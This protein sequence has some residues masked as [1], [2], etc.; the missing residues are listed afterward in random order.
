MATTS[1]LAGRLDFIRS[2]ERLK[3]VLRSGHTSSGRPESTAEHTWRLC[4]IAMTLQ[5]LLQPLDFERVLK[6]CIVHDLGEAISGDIPATVQ[7]TTVNKSERERR[8]LLLLTE[9]LPRH[10]QA[11]FLEL[12]AEYEAGETSE[13][14]VVKA[15]DKIE[16]II[17]HNQGANPPDFDYE[18]NISYGSKYASVHPVIAAL[19]ALV[20]EETHQNAVKAN[21]QPSDAEHLAQADPLRQAL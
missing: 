3:D 12:W 7:A 5:D 4:L 9:S 16:T 14:R 1:D 10:V 18:F 8:D 6:L 17:Q 19:R 21:R 20:D 2:A 11:S 15:L 13:A